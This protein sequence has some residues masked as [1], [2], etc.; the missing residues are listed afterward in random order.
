MFDLISNVKVYELKESLIAAGYPM[1]IFPD[2]NM[3]NYEF[4]EDDLSVINKDTILTME[5][6]EKL[7][8]RSKILGGTNIGEGHDNFLCGIRVAFDLKYPQYLTPELQRYHFIDIVS[9][10]SKMHR[11]T[12]MEVKK[13]VN[14]H[15]DQV[16]IK[17]L[18]SHIDAYNENPTHERF[19]K[20]V[21]NCPLGLYLFMR[22]NTNYRQLKTVYNQR[23]NHKL[24][25]WRQI[26]AWI[27]TLPLFVELTKIKRRFTDEN[28]KLLNL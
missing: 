16:V 19:M 22:L 4:F 24:H 1:K 3:G 20:V 26:C 13:C 8:D 18:Q 5:S 7:K 15:V 9:S 23:Y 14:E 6:L 21:S 11:L 25:E 27:E 10:S 17:N 12:K 2:I 28:G